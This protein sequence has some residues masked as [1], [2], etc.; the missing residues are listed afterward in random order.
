MKKNGW[1]LGVLTGALL[2]MLSVATGYADEWAG[3]F[4][5]E[6]TK[7]NAFTITLDADGTARGEKE[8]HVLNG[9]WSVDGASAVIKWTTGWTTKLSAKGNGYDKSAFRPGAPIEDEGAKVIA[10][11][12]VD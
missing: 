2:L 1:A 4:L 8:G 12:K 7:G 11:K 6:D 5:T 3:T 10:A 9:S